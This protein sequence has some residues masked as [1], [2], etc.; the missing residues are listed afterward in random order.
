MAEPQ[1][2]YQ[3]FLSATQGTFKASPPNYAFFRWIRQQWESF[4]AAN[5]DLPHSQ[6]S[7]AF[8]QWLTL[9][10]LSGQPTAKG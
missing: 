9:K 1:L 3:A 4:D 2:R 5:P 10:Y 6:R 8:D 7:A